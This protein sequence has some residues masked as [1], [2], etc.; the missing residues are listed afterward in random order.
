MRG[1]RT[2]YARILGIGLG[3]SLAV[4]I[5]VIG[6]GRWSSAGDTPTDGTL[7]VVTLPAPETP[8]EELEADLESA[9][10]GSFDLS[11]PEVRSTGVDLSEHTIV[12]AEAA[13]SDIREPLVPRPRINPVS[14]E[15]DL[16]PIRVREPALVTLGDRGRPSTGGGG[17]GIGILVGVGGRGHGDHCAPSAINIRYPTRPMVGANFPNRRIT[18]NFLPTARNHARAAARLG[19]RFLVG[20]FD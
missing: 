2:N 15:T 4:H 1:K 16:T 20:N 6:L 3:I 13:S 10:S 14:V 5:A 17:V 12:L 19:G 7:N 18:G 8:P 11:V 9:P